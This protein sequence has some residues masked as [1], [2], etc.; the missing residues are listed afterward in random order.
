MSGTPNSGNQSLG[1][2]AHLRVDEVCNRFEAVWKAGERPLLEDYLKDVASPERSVLLLEL[3]IIEILYRARNEYL[4]SAEF[5]QRFPED[6][7]VIRKAFEAVANSGASG[8]RVSGRQVASA[9]T[10]VDSE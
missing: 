3:L 4:T 8:S 9:D 10:G 1:P 6:S 5:K 2:S 7:Q